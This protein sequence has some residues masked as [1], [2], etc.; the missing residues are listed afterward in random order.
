[1]RR[2]LLIPVVTVALLAVAGSALGAGARAGQAQ[3]PVPITVSMGEFYFKLSKKT[4]TIPRGATKVTVAFKVVNKGAIQHDYAFAG[5]A[6]KT[7]LLNAGQKE[8]LKVTFK[9]KGR[10]P[11]LCTVP[12]HANAGMRGVFVVKKA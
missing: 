6:K 1:V 9:R 10:F 8:T 7:S 11:Y 3:A 4:V 2:R 5:L 12:R